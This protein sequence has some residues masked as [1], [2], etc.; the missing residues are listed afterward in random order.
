[1]GML[2]LKHVTSLAHRSLK[3][4]IE[5]GSRLLYQARVNPLKGVGNILHIE[6]WS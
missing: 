5:F 3:P 4:S 2:V 1:V 6:S